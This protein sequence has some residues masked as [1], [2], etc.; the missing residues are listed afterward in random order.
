PSVADITLA[1]RWQQGR[2]KGVSGEL[3]GGPV[4]RP[5]MPAGLY[6]P[7]LIG[8]DVFVLI[9][10]L[11]FD[12]AWRAVHAH[13]DEHRAPC[14]PAWR[15]LDHFAGHD[16]AQAISRHAGFAL[17]ASVRSAAAGPRQSFAAAS[18]D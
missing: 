1:L 5:D 10:A 3:G 6:A 4:I 8:L 16:M 18:P 12:T 2:G 13:R 9:A 14:G 17:T 11:P 7:A 15:R